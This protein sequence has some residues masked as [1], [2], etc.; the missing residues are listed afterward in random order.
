MQ[1]REETHEENHYVVIGKILDTYG[2]GGGL[3]LQ[4]YLDRKRWK[5]IRR[6]YLKRRGGPY[7][8]FELE[9]LKAHGK[10][11]LIVKFAGFDSLE[12]V[13]GFKGAK[14]F[15]PRKELPSKKRGEY[16]YFE[17][18]GLE[19]ITESGKPLGKVSGVVEQKPYDLLEID[20]GKTYVP[21]VKELVKDVNIEGRKLVVSNILSEL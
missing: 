12:K 19:V 10:D 9:S 13:K 18:E 15:L 3:K 20:G 16:Y 6:V 8:P 7:V 17:L 21:F 11:Q 2:L 14:V 1:K 4:A 5:G